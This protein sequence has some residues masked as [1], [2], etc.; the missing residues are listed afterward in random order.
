MDYVAK[1]PIIGSNRTIGTSTITGSR[2]RQVFGVVAVA[3][4][5]G[6][7]PRSRILYSL[8][9]QFCFLHRCVLYLDP[10]D[11]QDALWGSKHLALR[12]GIEISGLRYF[13]NV[14][15]TVFAGAQLDG[16]ILITQLD[17]SPN[18]KCSYYPAAC[19]LDNI[20]LSNN[21]PRFEQM[22]WN[23]SLWYGV[24]Y[25]KRNIWSIKYYMRLRLV[26]FYWRV[27]V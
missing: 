14:D 25:W 5:V 24:S 11:F 16:S 15:E 19:L 27:L 17:M 8:S 7:I 23:L 2:L 18:W 9:A 10:P 12:D 26:N 1:T 4:V 20:M 3:A 6:I 13:W 21:T 22:S